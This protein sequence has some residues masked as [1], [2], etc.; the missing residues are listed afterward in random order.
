MLTKELR[1][2]QKTRRET[3]HNSYRSSNRQEKIK[4]IFESTGFGRD[5][6]H[7]QDNT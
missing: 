3:R 2:T 1:D 5:L 4:I 6:A 7:F